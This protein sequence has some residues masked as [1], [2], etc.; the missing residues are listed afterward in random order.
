M[1]RTVRIWRS[2]G[3]TRG[4]ATSPVSVQLGGRTVEGYVDFCVRGEG[5]EGFV[6]GL[7]H[8][9]GGSFEEAAGAGDEEGVSCE[10]YFFVFV[11]EEVADRVLRM[12]RGVKTY[13]HVSDWIYEA[14]QGVIR[15]GTG[16]FNAADVEGFVVL[17]DVVC[18]RAVFASVHGQLGK[19][20]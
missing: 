4:Q 17:D 5:A 6:E 10:D 16:D 3:Y 19:V 15:K 18:H 9:L 12:A 20:L 14:F 11:F 8:F 7:V 1:T 2:R 13:K